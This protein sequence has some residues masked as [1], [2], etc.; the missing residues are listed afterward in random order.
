MKKSQIVSLMKTTAK[1]HNKYL[2]DEFLNKL[3]LKRLFGFIHP[4]TFGYY[5]KVL[6]KAEDEASKQPQNES[7]NRD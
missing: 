4:D 3:T 2:T 1:A 6:K 7:D 5:I